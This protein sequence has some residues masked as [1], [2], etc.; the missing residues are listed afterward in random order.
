M[1]ASF[2][3]EKVCLFLIIIDFLWAREVCFPCGSSDVAPDL[4][5]L[6]QGRPGKI[7]P[8]GPPGLTGGIG[9]PGLPGTCACDPNEIEL[10]KEELRFQKGQL[11]CFCSKVC[12]TFFPYCFHTN[13]SIV[14]RLKRR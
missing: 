2:F 11:R 4:P 9:E 1:S 14:S 10:L 5:Q 8:R 12:R 7:G 13:I 6:H 3:F